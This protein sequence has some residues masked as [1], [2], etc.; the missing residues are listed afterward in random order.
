MTAVASTEAT[1]WAIPPQALVEWLTL[2]ALVD[3]IGAV[4][5]RTSDPEAW[6]P[7]RGDVNGF[8]ARMAL[9]ACSGCLPRLRAGGR[10]SR[11]DL[12]WTA[13][14]RAAENVGI[15][16]AGKLTQWCSQER[17]PSP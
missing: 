6:W 11:G 16:F 17:S 2:A 4:P 15:G 12:G 8:A 13:A 1:A 10:R 7:D 5:C 9:D 3:E 14:E